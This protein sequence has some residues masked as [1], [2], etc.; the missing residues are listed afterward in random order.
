MFI[1]HTSYF[2]PRAFDTCVGVDASSIHLEDVKRA[3]VKRGENH[4]ATLI[5]RV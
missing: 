2:D 1:V 5:L 4:I 3:A